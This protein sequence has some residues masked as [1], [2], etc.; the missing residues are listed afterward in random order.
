MTNGELDVCFGQPCLRDDGSELAVIGQ[1]DDD[2]PIV[3][4]PVDGAR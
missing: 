2:G 1:H 4:N 3:G